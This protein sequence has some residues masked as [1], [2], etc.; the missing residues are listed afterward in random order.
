[1]WGY[2][3]DALKPEVAIPIVFTL[4]F[5]WFVYNK[6]KPRWRLWYMSLV[7][8]QVE[9]PIASK[10]SIRYENTVIERA[11]VERVMLWNGGNQ[12]ILSDDIAPSHPITIVVKGGQIFD[13]SVVSRLED[14]NKII[15]RRDLESSFV[16]DFD[17]LAVQDGAVLQVI[18]NSNEIDA[19]TFSG[20]VK[21]GGCPQ[22]IM[23]PARHLARRSALFVARADAWYNMIFSIPLVFLAVWSL[24]IPRDAIAI[25]KWILIIAVFLFITSLRELSRTH[26][27][28]ALS[29]GLLEQEG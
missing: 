13:V 10:I 17:Y 19:V 29:K 18:H 14:S 7:M 20:I 9:K 5:G 12:R 11:I 1:M 23:I 26:V 28:R 15:T 3:S 2:L 22:R 21:G 25:S 8:K 4:L 6:S 16:L 27:P 24:H